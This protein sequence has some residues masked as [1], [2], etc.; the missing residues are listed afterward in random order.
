[1]PDLKVRWQRH[2]IG[3]HPETVVTAVVGL[4]RFYLRAQ[5]QLLARRNAAEDLISLLDPAVDALERLL[6]AAGLSDQG[7]TPLEPAP[8]EPIA[9]PSP[10]DRP[11]FPLVL[12]GYWPQQVERDL[13][14]FQTEW[15]GELKALVAE[16]ERLEVARSA[17]VHRLLVADRRLR[18][19]RLNVNVA[20]L[21][22]A[23]QPEKVVPI[24]RKERQVVP[25]ALIQAVNAPRA[26][27]VWRP[28]MVEVS[29]AAETFTMA[30]PTEGFTAGAGYRPDAPR[31]TLAPDP[32]VLAAAATQAPTG[33]GWPVP[34]A[35]VMAPPTIPEA[36][37]AP[38]DTESP[39]SAPGAPPTVE[40]ATTPA[41]AGT[42]PDGA[43]AQLQAGLK[44]RIEILFR[45]FLT[46]KV[47][48]ADLFGPGGE[49]L[50]TK[51]TPITRELVLKAEQ[52][53]VLP[54]LIA[55]MTLPELQN[56]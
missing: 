54:S 35:G 8:S 36:T 29:S 55:H 30:G 32:G 50:A 15:Q 41:E 31:R 17:L 16:V 24:R 10:G 1:M 19:A 5:Q 25:P 21:A 14:R 20:H 23:R 40:P 34:T 13:Q 53:G 9:L 22:M 7:P 33:V 26:M 11:F 56:E 38:V 28:G 39:V 45:R 2:V 42:P 52:A 51:G 18:E 44:N 27:E 37:P 4:E 12:F 49:V 48:G 3:Y 6:K 47:L 46:D 43:E